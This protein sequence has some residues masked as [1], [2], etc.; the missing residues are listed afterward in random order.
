MKTLAPDMLK[1]YRDTMNPQF[2]EHMEAFL[3]MSPQ[4][5]RELLFFGLAYSTSQYAALLRLLHG[6]PTG[7]KTN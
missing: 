2:R 3:A 4:D 7:E 5:Q 1:Q 6:M